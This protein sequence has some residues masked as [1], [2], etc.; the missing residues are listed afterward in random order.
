MRA[1][2]FVD[3]ATEDVLEKYFSPSTEG[4]SPFIFAMLHAWCHPRAMAPEPGPLRSKLVE[5]MKSLGRTQPTSGYDRFFCTS[6]VTYLL[7]MMYRPELNAWFET[8]SSLRPEFSLFHTWLVYDL[9][10]DQGEQADAL[11][12]LFMLSSQGLK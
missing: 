12:G 5:T 2:G 9:P 4:G 3:R 8:I 7:S 10:F 11:N 6:A 1:S